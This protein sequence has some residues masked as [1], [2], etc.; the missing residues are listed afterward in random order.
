MKILDSGDK[1]FYWSKRTSSA[2]ILGLFCIVAFFAFGIFSG[3]ASE[4]KKLLVVLWVLIFFLG[5]VILILGYETFFAKTPF[6][7]IS[8]KIVKI[9]KVPLFELEQISSAYIEGKFIIIEFKD[10][11]K[12]KQISKKF[13]SG[14]TGIY[15]LLLSSEDV[16]ILLS[17]LNGVK[18]KTNEH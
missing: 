17:L 4:D 2:L 10:H 1:A 8:D 7:L 3:L 9:K 12:M 16:E 18:I 13:V 14:K 15:A 6:V 11:D 5:P